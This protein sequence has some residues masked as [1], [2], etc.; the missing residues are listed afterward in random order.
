M[1]DNPQ[2][3]SV[4]YSIK[5]EEAV[6]GAI[7][8]NPDSYYNVAQFLQAE[9]FYIHRT[10]FIWEA[11]TRLYQHRTPVDF[12]TLTEEVDRAGQLAE[13][14]GPAYLTEL[15][16]QVPSSLHAEAYAQIIEQAAV[17]RRMLEA[18]GQMAKLAFDEDTALENV[19][20]ETEKAIFSINNRLPKRNIQSLSQVLEPLYSQVEECS[21]HTSFSGV[22]TGF[23]ALDH[24]LQGLQPSDLV[25]V[26]GR[27]G[28]GKTS[29]LLSI[30]R[31]A[32]KVHKSHIFV[33][34]LET[35]KEQLSQRL[36]AQETG[37]ELQ[38]IRSG[39]LKSDEWQL[40]ADAIETLSEVHLFLDDTP[41]ITMHQICSTCRQLH[42]NKKLDLLVVDYLQLIS[43]G[44]RFENRVQEVS[45]ITRQLKALACELNL[46]VLAAAQLSRAV[47][48]R[49]DKHPLL[50]DLRESGSIEM[51]ADVV[52]FLY[53]PED[54]ETS[55]QV[56][57]IV[58]KHRNGPTGKV[59]LSFQKSL[60]M[61][62]N[63]GSNG[64]V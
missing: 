33:I 31:H 1:P 7:L 48:Q 41:A 4:P 3:K 15:I 22:P 25:I 10:R 21:Q 8:I 38:R 32:A 23:V 40:L 13:V 37:I 29:L 28:M 2:P 45:Y 14:G 20:N 54:S 49:A 53:H 30:A 9:D 18:A 58:A 47:E 51:D 12:L 5:A 42:M 59:R 16:N 63:I 57:I 60:A 64:E 19:I 35:S 43:G 62:E 34:T 6:I 50:S 46:P 26:A 39:K 36:V 56:D 52:M 17:R 61:F 55:K 24:L 11:I 44:E 27:P